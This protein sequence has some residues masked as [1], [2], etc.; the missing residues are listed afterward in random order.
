MAMV[1]LST[2]RRRRHPLHTDD[3]LVVG[4]GFGGTIPRREDGFRDTVPAIG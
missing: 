2:L 4:I 1:R 3:A